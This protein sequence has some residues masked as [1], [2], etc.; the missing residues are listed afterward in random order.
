MAVQK[1][2]YVY[3]RWLSAVPG[4]GFFL[5]C[6][7]TIRRTEKESYNKRFRRSWPTGAAMSMDRAGPP[8]KKKRKR[9]SAVSKVQKTFGFRFEE[10]R[11]TARLLL[12][13]LIAQTR[14]FRV[15]TA[16]FRTAVAC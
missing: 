14:T 1:Q 7:S 8:T 12:C 11:S 10:T 4:G 2:E 13:A 9:L 5:A 6:W 3:C 16:T 15:G